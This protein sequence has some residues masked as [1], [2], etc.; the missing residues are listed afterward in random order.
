M[1]GT[2]AEAKAE[3]DLSLPRKMQ[4]QFMLPDNTGWQASFIVRRRRTQVRMDQPPRLIQ[5][6]LADH[7]SFLPRGLSK[8]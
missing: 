8:N 1:K 7:G 5:T 6:V 3:M 2:S 4:G